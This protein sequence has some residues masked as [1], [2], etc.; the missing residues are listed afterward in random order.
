MDLAKT[1][2]LKPLR[3]HAAI[4]L[5]WAIAVLAMLAGSI[6]GVRSCAAET[7]ARC[8]LEHISIQS[9]A[10]RTTRHATGARRRSIAIANSGY[11]PDINTSAFVGREGKWTR[12]SP[13][14]GNSHSVTSPRGYSIDLVQPIFRGFQTTNAVNAAE[15]TDRA[16][17]ETLRQVEQTVLLDAVTA[18]GDVVR[19]QAIVKLDEN[20]LSFLDAELKATQDRFNVGEV[21]K[22]DVAQAQARLAQGQS[23]LDQARANLKS[24]RAI[25]EQV[26]G[27]PPSRLVEANPNTKLVPRSIDE[28]VAI[29]TKENPQVVQALYS[30]QAAR[31]TVDQIRGQLLPQAELDASYTDNFDPSEQVSTRPRRPRSSVA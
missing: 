13:A 1:P 26:I 23:D 3:S 6:V 28:A 9:D 29:G 2:T 27:H 17:R 4:A 14:I 31:Y 21:T 24:S 22:T 10:R 11:R 5:Q 8:A 19:D 30:E 12:S 16:G 25:Y 15:A 7:S 20:N 18:F